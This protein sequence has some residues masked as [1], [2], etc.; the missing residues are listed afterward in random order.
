MKT[1]SPIVIQKG[2]QTK[3]RGVGEANKGI[4]I[5]NDGRG[6]LKI[7]VEE[8][9]FEALKETVNQNQE[10]K[11][12]KCYLTGLW[13]PLSEGVFIDSSMMADAM[14]KNLVSQKEVMDLFKKE[15][16]LTCGK[17]G[18]KIMYG[19]NKEIR[20]P[21]CEEITVVKKYYKKIK[22]PETKRIAFSLY[23][24]YL[25]KNKK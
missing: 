6:L 16:V 5:S 18:I 12:Y 23:I 17:C 8:K 10:D 11:Q 15:K 14:E 1:A 22:L 2:E 3:N 24:K 25:R 19:D 21:D 7:A 20:C 13:Y 9:V 4:F